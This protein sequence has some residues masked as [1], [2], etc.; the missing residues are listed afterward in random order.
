MGDLVLA[1]KSYVDAADRFCAELTHAGEPDFDGLLS[2]AVLV[3][4]SAPG[5]ANKAKATPSKDHVNESG[6]SRETSKSSG[7]GSKGD[8]KYA[9]GY[10]QGETYSLGYSKGNQGGHWNNYGKGEKKRTWYSKD[11]AWPHEAS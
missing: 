2:Q 8:G 1:T 10:G 6:K 4:D 11:S 5:M 7:K 3:L 9:G